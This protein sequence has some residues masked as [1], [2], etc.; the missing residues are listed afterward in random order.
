MITVLLLGLA[1]NWMMGPEKE[2]VE[3]KF[4]DNLKDDMIIE[5]VR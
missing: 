3:V 4:V 2:V 5:I 1:L